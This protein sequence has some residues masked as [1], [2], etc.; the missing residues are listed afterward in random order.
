MQRKEMYDLGDPL[1]PLARVE[2]RQIMLDLLAIEPHHIVVDVPAWGGYLAEGITNIL[3]PKQI[4]CVEP[5]NRFA[6]SISPRFDVRCTSQ[7]TLPLLDASVD[8]VGSM[9]GMHHLDDK[10]AFVRECVRVL[11]PGGRLA[12][13]E[14]VHDSDVAKFLNG[15]VDRYTTNGHKGAFVKPGEL[16]D[17][18][19]AA[20]CKGL[21]E[22]LYHLFWRFKTLEE[23]ARFARGLLGLARATEQQTIEAIQEHFELDITMNVDLEII[24]VKWP[25]SLAYVVGVRP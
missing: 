11:K 25:W 23:L 14:V 5:S 2:E 6:A 13:S 18:L 17:L 16:Y 3:D 20:G 15:P 7:L 24:E 4:I 1:S 10:L 12:F 21:V 19:Y 8:R 22:R 9:V